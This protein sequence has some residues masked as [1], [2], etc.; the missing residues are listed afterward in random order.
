MVFTFL[1]ESLLRKCFGARSRVKTGI[2]TFVFLSLL[3]MCLEAW[4]EDTLA[5]LKEVGLGLAEDVEL[6]ELG[7]DG[8]FLSSNE[9]DALAMPEDL[10]MVEDEFHATS[11]EATTSGDDGGDDDETY[12]SIEATTASVSSVAYPALPAVIAALMKPEDGEWMNQL[13]EKYDK[14]LSPSKQGLLTPP[15][16]R[17]ISI[18]SHGRPP[19]SS[20]RFTS[21]QRQRSNGLPHLPHRPLRP[22]PRLRNLHPRPPQSLASKTR[23]AGYDT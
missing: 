5:T 14:Y 13:A 7:L 22:P 9:E 2:L 4:R 1:M 3:F 21:K 16:F 8:D 20:P 12:T 15:Q 23:H 18:S 17:H 19:R 10:L 6:D 11:E